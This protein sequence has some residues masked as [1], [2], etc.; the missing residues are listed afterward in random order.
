M[1]TRKPAVAGSPVIPYLEP[2]TVGYCLDR[3]IHRGVVTAPKKIKLSVSQSVD[4]KW[5]EEVAG[6]FERVENPHSFA[7]LGMYYWGRPVYKRV[8]NSASYKWDYIKW[9]SMKMH[10]ELLPKEVMEGS[11]GLSSGDALKFDD[12]CVAMASDAPVPTS[13]TWQATCF[14]DADVA[15]NDHRDIQITTIDSTPP[16]VC[17]DGEVQADAGEE[18]DDGNLLPADGCSPTCKQDI[19]D[20]TRWEHGCVTEAGG[21]CVITSTP[22]QGRRLLSDTFDAASN[23][24]KASHACLSSKDSDGDGQPDCLDACPLDPDAQTSEECPVKLDVVE[25]P[26]NDRLLITAE[27]KM[28][29]EILLN[30]RF[31]ESAASIG[32]V[33]ATRKD[34]AGSHWSLSVHTPGW[35][36]GHPFTVRA[37][38]YVE[39]V[40]GDWSNGICSRLPPDDAGCVAL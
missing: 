28:G 38:I 20:A 22:P 3:K 13:G 36:S 17:G 40:P 16:A 21:G 33:P 8:G 30:V 35:H 29:D 11:D 4:D 23:R 5:R 7:G 12:A 32:P 6:E 26:T 14:K 10:W 2:N 15:L 25:D 37:K 31:G 18:C 34:T 27:H 19:T 9:N 24:L 1:I 39:G